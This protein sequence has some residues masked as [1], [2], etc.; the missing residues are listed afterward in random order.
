MRGAVRLDD[1]R[2]HRDRHPDAR[3]QDHQVLPDAHHQDHRGRRDRGEDRRSHPDAH[4]LGYPVAANTRRGARR[5]VRRAELDP[6]HRDRQAHRGARCSR[7][8]GAGHWL[9]G[10]ARDVAHCR[11][12]RP[13]AVESFCLM[14]TLRDHSSVAVGSVGQK[15]RSGAQVQEPDA[16]A[17]VQLAPLIAVAL[18]RP[19]GAPAR[20]R[21]GDCW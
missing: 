21:P 13:E 6:L 12:I 18:L 1:H 7:R 3:H 9:P 15:P 16:Q 17:A 14:P 20:S 11:L 19:R 2:G 5:R 4:P 8:R 10:L